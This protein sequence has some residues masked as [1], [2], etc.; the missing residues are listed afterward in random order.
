PRAELDASIHAL[1]A[2][3]SPA[4]CQF[5][6]RFRF[7][8][9][10][11]GWPTDGAFDHCQEYLQWRAEVPDGRVAL[12]FPATYLNSPSSMFGHTLLRLDKAGEEDDVWLS[13]AIN[14]GAVVDDA[15]SSML[16]IYRGLAG[17]YN[18]YFSTVAYHSKVQDYAHIE[19]RDMCEYPLAL[20]AE[21]RQ[22]VIEHLWEMKDVRFDYFFLDENCSLRL[23]ELVALARPGTDMLADFRLTEIPVN[24]VRAVAGAGL[25]E[26]QIYRPSKASE[27]T[28]LEEQ[29]TWAQRRLAVRLAQDTAVAESKVF[30]QHQ[31]VEQQRM[32]NA[33]YNWL[34]FQQQGKA[35]V[36]R[37]AQH[38]MALLRLLN[39]YSPAP[40]TAVVTPERPE[41]G[42]P[43]KMMA[44][45]AGAYDGKTFGQWEYR[46]TYHDWLDPPAGFLPGAHI[47]AL[48]L[49]LRHQAQDKLRWQALT[50]VD[51]RSLA[52][53]STFI[54]P[55]SWFVRGGLE[56]TAVAG[57][58]RLAS[59]VEGGP[60]AA[61][62]WRSLRPYVYA[63][64]RLEHHGVHAQYVEP[65]L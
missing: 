4:R 60:G 37:N 63:T 15:D 48:H 50:V 44:A 49:Q 2:A 38:S 55:L 64:G 5:P 57:A 28:A 36:P 25:I 9:E 14:F 7:L 23:L 29:L 51:I 34:R 6:A 17:G 62:R 35:C 30:K 21:E 43:T 20:T 12:V 3:G 52:P 40:N 26:Q 45:S 31:Q 56:R 19:N 22:W 54:K 39:A 27:L 42:H 47:E 11:F 58:Y 46:L 59:Y 1:Q 10:A 53:R 32:L 24:T 33:A 61:W 16:Y 13:W 41:T 8:A 65:G 18:G